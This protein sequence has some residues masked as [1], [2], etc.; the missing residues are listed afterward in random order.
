MT[1]IQIQDYISQIPWVVPM[2]RIR[3]YLRDIRHLLFGAFT[4]DYHPQ[5]EL[6]ENETLEDRKKAE[7]AELQRQA[8]LAGA[9]MPTKEE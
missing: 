2:E 3:Y 6:E 5:P 1:H 4:K 9:P 8:I 7:F